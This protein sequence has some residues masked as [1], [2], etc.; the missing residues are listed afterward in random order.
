VELNQVLVRF[1]PPGGGDADAFTRAVIARVQQ[2][3]VCW[4]AGTRWHDQE[5]MR[6]SVSGWA[7]NEEDADRSAEAIL[8]ARDAVGKR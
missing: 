6:L 4:L 5:A 8:A 1:Q 7:T 3:G 2:D